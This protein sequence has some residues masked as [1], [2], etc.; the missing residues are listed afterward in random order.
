MGFT[1]AVMGTLLGF[2]FPAAFYLK[3]FEADVD[4]LHF[5]RAGRWIA[6]SMLGVGCVFMVV[7]VSAQVASMAGA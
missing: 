6:A 4:H 7:C 3:R 2:I 5:P 1:G